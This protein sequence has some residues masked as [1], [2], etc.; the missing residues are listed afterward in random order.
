MVYGY[1]RQLHGLSSLSEQ[2]RDILSFSLANDIKIDK[3]VVEYSNRPLRIEERKEF[4]EF[5][6]SL[7]KGDSIV[8]STLSAFSQRA[9]EL[10]KL[11]NCSLSKEVT[12]YVASPKRV[13]TKRT[14]ILDIFP[15]L[16]DIREAEASKSTQL[17][18]P[19]GSRSSS[20]FDKFKAQILDLLKEGMS[21][22]A[23]SRE[24]GLSRSSLKD[25]IE[26]RNLKELVEGSW[27]E[28]NLPGEIKESEDR[29]LICPFEKDK[30]TK[31][32]M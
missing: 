27:L 30:I 7:S 20:K 26:S 23:I 12:L 9:E 18:R 19:K 22:S 17:G 21:V 25:Y 29:V 32:V 5:L 3:E 10:I 13:I 24:L 11:I 16:N 4:E 14:Q 31:E 8:V 1:I 28:V 15:L 2:Q 6:R